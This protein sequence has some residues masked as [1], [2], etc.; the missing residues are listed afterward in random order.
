MNECRLTKKWLM[1]IGKC[2]TKRLLP[3]DGHTVVKV[4]LMKSCDGL[5]Y[6]K[7]I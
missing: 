7:D 3:L 1:I 5:F 2:Q 6:E 4:F